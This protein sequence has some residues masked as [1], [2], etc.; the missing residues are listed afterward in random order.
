MN[1]LR[2]FVSNL[3]EHL[4]EI[5]NMLKKDSVVKWTEEAM[6]SFNLVKLALCSA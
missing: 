4:S 3:V 2:L 5:T 6:K 1:F